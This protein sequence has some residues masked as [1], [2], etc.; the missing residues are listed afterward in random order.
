MD[1]PEIDKEL[2]ILAADDV[3]SCGK[4]YCQYRNLRRW[5]RFG[6]RS[7]S[8]VNSSMRRGAAQLVAVAVTVDPWP[9]CAAAAPTGH[10]ARNGARSR[11]PGHE[12]DADA[13]RLDGAAG[14][15][16]RVQRL[17][18]GRRVVAH[19]RAGEGRRGA[20]VRIR[21]GCSS[22]SIPCRSPPRRSHSSRLPCSPRW[23]WPRSASAW[24][25]WSYARDFATRP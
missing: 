9:H 12:E 16:R 20:R 4:R 10:H 2:S 7:T 25:T 18:A 1:L 17:A 5:V 23:R 8:G 6:A 14:L 13:G 19:G 24:A 21:S 22:T 15:E 3:H 11:P